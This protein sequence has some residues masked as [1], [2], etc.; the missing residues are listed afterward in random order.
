M[1]SQNKAQSST[2]S[3]IKKEEIKQVDD[4]KENDSDDENFVEY[5]N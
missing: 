4:E 2:R 1:H 3:N 5:D